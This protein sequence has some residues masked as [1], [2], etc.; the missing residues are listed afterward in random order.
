MNEIVGGIYSWS[1]HNEEKGIDFNGHF[2]V[3]AGGR[4]LVDP[5]PMDDAT[6]ARVESIGP[7][8]VIVVT[9]AHHSRASESFAARWKIPIVVPEAD[10]A[11]LPPGIRPGGVHRDGDT[12]PGGL[13]VIALQDQKT[14][15]ETALLC[16]ASSSLILGDALI[17]RPAGSLSML[18]AAKFADIGRARAGLA[19]LRDLPFEAL[20]LG[21]GGS[22]PRGGKAAL[23]R[24]LES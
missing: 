15:G 3:N 20:L 17:G 24:F 22:I 12:L 16:R 8:T 14:P 9:N 21:D 6:L 5:P 10:A 23:L 7:P 2:V 19:R 4:A 1:V 18:P 13:T 11:L